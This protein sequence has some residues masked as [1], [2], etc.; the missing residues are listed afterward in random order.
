[1]SIKRFINNTFPDNQIE[2]ITGFQFGIPVELLI[3]KD[4][5]IINDKETLK[6]FELISEILDLKN[7]HK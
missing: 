6:S 7:G 1:M 2:K 4:L 3:N 5:Q